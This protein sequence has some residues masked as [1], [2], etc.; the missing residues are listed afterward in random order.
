MN[1][2]INLQP[3][4]N[5]PKNKDLGNIYFKKYLYPSM[6]RINRDGLFFSL[7]NNVF[8]PNLTPTPHIM[9]SRF[10]SFKG[11]TDYYRIVSHNKFQIKNQSTYILLFNLS[12]ATVPCVALTDFLKWFKELYLTKS[13]DIKILAHYNY[14]LDI[15]NSF[16]QNYIV[17]YFQL[18]Q[19][20]LGRIP[21]SL[22]VVDLEKRPSFD[23]YI[24]VE[25]ASQWSCLD[26]YLVHLC[27]S[28]GAFLLQP[29]LEDL[30]F[31][32]ISTEALSPNHSIQKVKKRYPD[33]F[34]ICC[35]FENDLK[36]MNFFKHPEDLKLFFYLMYN[37]IF[38]V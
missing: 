24:V 36:E 31:Q 32:I 7:F 18:I 14:D 2:K 11:K 27:L 3:F 16:D 17:S 4:R 30:K 20:I 23:G 21:D 12:P 34:D 6:E 28:K 15:T 37:N 1:S 5:T 19:N 13:P 10:E 29:S 25:A 26:N 35:P 38:N 8:D 9:L 33:E 22:S